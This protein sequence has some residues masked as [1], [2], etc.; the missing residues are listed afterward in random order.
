MLEVLRKLA[1]RILTDEPSGPNLADRREPTLR[2]N[3]RGQPANETVASHPTRRR[4][5]AVA[6]SR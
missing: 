2:R 4:I 1:D 6:S 3:G 5:G